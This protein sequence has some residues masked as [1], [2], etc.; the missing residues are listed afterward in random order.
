MLTTRDTLLHFHTSRKENFLSA[1]IAAPPS[2][3]YT[4][5]SDEPRMRQ[6]IDSPS[7]PGEGRGEGTVILHSGI[8]G[9]FC[10]CEEPR[11]EAIS[12]VRRVR[13]LRSA[14]NDR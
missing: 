6:A 4:R 5:R 12:G 8:N 11:D 10:H 14:R 7:P 9:T 2:L 1:F 3:C 13:L